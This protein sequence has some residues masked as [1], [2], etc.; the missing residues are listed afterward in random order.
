[1]SDLAQTNKTTITPIQFLPL[2]AD[3]LLKRVKAGGFSGHYLARAFI[4]SYRTSTPFKLS[5]GGLTRL[6]LE[7]LNVFHQILHIRF[8]SNWNDDFLYKLE[9]EII[10][11]NGGK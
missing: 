7:A 8:T 10:A 1:M 3:L 11:L 5:L 4:S 2:D 9:Q 6:D